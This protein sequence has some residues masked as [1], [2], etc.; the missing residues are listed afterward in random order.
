LKFVIIIIDIRVQIL[1]RIKLVTFLGLERHIVSGTSTG[2]ETPM[3]EVFSTN[4]FA[5]FKGNFP[6]WRLFVFN[7][8]KLEIIFNQ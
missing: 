3:K 8:H 6:L 5:A 7:G 4:L 1:L 2:E